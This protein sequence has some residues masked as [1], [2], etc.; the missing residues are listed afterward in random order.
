[1]KA[2]RED[3]V[4]DPFVMVEENGCFCARRV[5][6]QGHDRIQRRGVAGEHRR[7]LIDAEF[8]LNEGGG[9]DTDGK[10]RLVGQR[11]QIGESTAQ[12]FRLETLNPGGRG[13]IPVPDNAI[14]QL[15]DALVKVR[16]LKF[17]VRLNDITR[18]SFAH[19]GAARHDEAGRAMTAIVADP[20]DEAAAA[21]LDTD[22]IWRSMLR[23][24]CVATLLETGRASN[25]LP[26]RA[27]AN[28]NAR[29][30]PGL[31]G[32]PD[33]NG[34]HGLDERVEVRSAYIG[35]DYPGD[36]ATAC[37]SPG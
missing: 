34:T 1:M 11:V 10:G 5:R 20:R 12:N 3:R 13:S 14:Y 27:T 17:P 7:E 18:A 21:I 23:T 15:A 35:R 28:V 4:R 36:L 2:T 37:A 19:N 9:G 6:R 33:G 8:A 30:V 16:A 31:W 26:Q 24:T 22:R 29:I 32:N 25:A